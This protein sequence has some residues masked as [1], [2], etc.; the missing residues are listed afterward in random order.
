MDVLSKRERS[1]SVS[2]FL[3]SCAWDFSFLKIPA[4]G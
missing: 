1:T 2:S 4:E 3:G